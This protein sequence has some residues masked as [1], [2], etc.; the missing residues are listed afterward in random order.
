M[1][2]KY[3]VLLVIV[4]ALGAAIGLRLYQQSRAPEVASIDKIQLQT[5]MP[6]R[7][8]EVRRRDLAEEVA[9]S[10]G[11]EAFLEA[12]V[13]PTIAERIEK[14]H[15]TTGQRVKA[16][17]LLVTLDSV[18]GRLNLAQAQA[19]EG[20]AAENLRKLRNGSRPEEIA[21]ALAQVEE[22]RAMENLRRIEVERQQGLYDEEATQLRLL[23][24]S[25]N[26]YAG[27]QAAR[28]AAEAQYELVKEG[29]RSEDIAIAETQLD[30]AKVAVAQAQNALDDHFLKA[31]FAGVVSV[32]AFEIGDILDVQAEMFRVAQIDKVYLV[33][34]VSEIYL[35]QVSVGMTVNVAVDA[36]PGK[37]FAGTVAE[38]NPLG[39]QSDR[40]F[41]TK[42]LL[43]NSEG[44]L[45]PGMFGRARIVT[46]TSSGAIAVPTDAVKA[47][48]GTKYVLL[49]QGGGGDAAEAGETL[50][51]ERVDVT[52]GRVFGNL[53]EI[54]AGLAE[55]DEVIAFTQQIVEAGTKVVIAE[56]TDG[57]ER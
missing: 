40:S 22:A 13:A 2:K 1:K 52:A 51:A 7:V 53:I 28:A 30:L 33:I 3:L 37:A 29:P 39:R 27:A 32:N 12:A 14:I 47:E 55:G 23:Q 4:L 34:D 11:I 44:Q 48:N 41:A 24:E 56:R 18:L 6:V 25:Q 35:A 46:D 16:G 49:A 57:E 26:Q 19:A 50:L 8:F 5:G 15:V 36:L 17:E 42:I 43:D 38:I 54:T 20:Q 31:P 9:I 45:R 21:Q 10:G